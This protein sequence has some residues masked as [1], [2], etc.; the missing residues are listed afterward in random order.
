[1][2]PTKIFRRG[3]MTLQKNVIEKQTFGEKNTP[4]GGVYARNRRKR[5]GRGAYRGLPELGVGPALEEEVR[6]IEEALGAGREQWR[7]CV[8][9]RLI[10]EDPWEGQRTGPP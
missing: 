6:H 10:D 8:L 1:V 2:V 9:T 5:E 4:L 7:L 3:E